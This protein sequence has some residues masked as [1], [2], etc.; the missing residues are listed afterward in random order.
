MTSS[1]LVL[2]GPGAG[3]C[4]CKETRVCLSM[5]KTIQQYY[6]FVLNRVKHTVD[7]CTRLSPPPE[8]NYPGCLALWGCLVAPS[9]VADFHFSLPLGTSVITACYTN[10]KPGVH[11]YNNFWLHPDTPGVS[12]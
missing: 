8:L 6:S 1:P 2:A 4:V 7:R 12:G 5:L 10:S 11:Q 3:T 9:C